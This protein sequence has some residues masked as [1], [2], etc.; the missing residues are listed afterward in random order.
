MARDAETNTC[1][2]L[3]GWAENENEIGNVARQKSRG[4][5]LR[6]LRTPCWHAQATIFSLSLSRLVGRHASCLARDAFSPIYTAAGRAYWP[7]HSSTALRLC[8]HPPSHTFAL[9]LSGVSIASCKGRLRSNRRAC[10]SQA[11]GWQGRIAKAIQSKAERTD[12]LPLEAE[13][14]LLRDRS[15]LPEEGSLKL[16]QYPLEESGYVCVSV[17][18]RSKGPAARSLAVALLVWRISWGSKKTAERA[19]KSTWI[20]THSTS[21]CPRRLACMTDSSSWRC[22]PFTFACPTVL[23]PTLL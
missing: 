1:L 18:V 5:G 3:S 17:R 22:P 12:V 14:F 15:S 23:C 21:E 4:R 10:A 16:R 6:L 7:T 8:S 2:S 9:N 11:S 20:P 13:T 19:A